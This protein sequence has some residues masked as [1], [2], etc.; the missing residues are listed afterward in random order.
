V[1]SLWHSSD[2]DAA[3]GTFRGFVFRRLLLDKLG[4]DHFL[5]LRPNVSVKARAAAFRG[6]QVKVSPSQASRVAS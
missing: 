1:A 3:T 5:E 2:A 6:P 4:Y